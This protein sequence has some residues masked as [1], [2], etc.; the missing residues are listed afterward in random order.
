MAGASCW[1]LRWRI[2]MGGGWTASGA[3]TASAVPF[4]RF[5]SSAKAIEVEFVEVL[6]E[7]NAVGEPL[8]DVLNRNA[9]VGTEAGGAAHP[10][11]VDPG[12]LL[13]GYGVQGR[14]PFSFVRAGIVVAA[15]LVGSWIAMFPGMSTKSGRLHHALTFMSALAL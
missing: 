3:W 5:C 7:G 11:W 8:E 13:E 12:G 4:G 9:A 10:F 15:A 2:F 6:L 1:V 14:L